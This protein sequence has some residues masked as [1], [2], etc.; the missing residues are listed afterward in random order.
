MPSKHSMRNSPTVVPGI[1]SS[2]AGRCLVSNQGGAWPTSVAPWG[3]C[4]GTWV[5][6]GAVGGDGC[7]SA[8]NMPEPSGAGATGKV[9]VNEG[10]STA[11]PQKPQKCAVGEIC[12][13]Q[14]AHIGMVG[15][16]GPDSSPSGA[17]GFIRYP[18]YP[19]T[20]CRQ[21]PFR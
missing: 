17:R 16:T 18:P 7:A 13:L 5:T 12:A 8:P 20:D 15:L 21:V 14:C 1:S 9:G 10:T 6:A 11:A 2:M 4:P 3:A 19:R